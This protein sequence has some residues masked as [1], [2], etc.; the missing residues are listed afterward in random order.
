MV[1]ILVTTANLS[2][3]TGVV[4]VEGVKMTMLARLCFPCTKYATV[5]FSMPWLITR[6]I[7]T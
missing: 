5:W 3:I 4:I 7:L 2:P 1:T 6:P